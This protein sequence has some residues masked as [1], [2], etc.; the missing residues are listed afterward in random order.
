MATVGSEHHMNPFE[1][2]FTIMKDLRGELRDVTSAL[3][4]EQSQRASEVGELR[5]EATSLQE[6]LAR[7]RAERG[8]A[9]QKLIEN[10]AAEAT[11]RKA[12]VDELKA[13]LRTQVAKLT[14]QLEDEA[15]DRNL[16]QKDLY[17]KLDVEV[18]QRKAECSSLNKELG[19]QKKQIDAGD[20]ERQLS[21]HHLTE[22]VRLISDHCKAV[23]RVW[24]SFKYE[25]LMSFGGGATRRPLPG[26]ED[27]S[28]PG[29]PRA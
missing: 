5:R 25:S 22:D 14:N 26:G 1:Q 6:E 28:V 10:L 27:S 2:A 15:N 9:V 7:E 21:V 11:T 16:K 23:D 29:P 19:D 17:A 8:A 18:T 3:K 4:A 20:R 13:S 12:E 24:S